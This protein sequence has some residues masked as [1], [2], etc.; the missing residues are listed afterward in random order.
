LGIA[1]V[2]TSKGVMTDKAARKQ[3]FGGEVICVVA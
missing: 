3:G 1:I 2:T